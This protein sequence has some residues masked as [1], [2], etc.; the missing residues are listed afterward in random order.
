MLIFVMGPKTVWQSELKTDVT[1]KG[2][3]VWKLPT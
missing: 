3:F 2:F 1:V